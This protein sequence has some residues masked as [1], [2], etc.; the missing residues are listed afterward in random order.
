MAK[1]LYCGDCAVQTGFGRVAE[2]ILPMLAKEH[3]VVVL[4]VNYWGD[5]HDFSFRLYPAMIGGSDPFGS[6]RIAEVLQKE[7]P[8][9]V[10]AVNDIWI[11]NKLWE[12]A[13]PLKEELGFKWY[14]YFPVDSYGFFPDVFKPC[15][16]WDGMGT[17]TQFGMQEVRKAGC[18]LPCDV[19]PHGIN[20][21]HFYKLDKAACREEFK[22]SDEL[23]IVFNG[24]RNQPRKRIDLTIRGFLKF[25]EGKPDA[26][27]WLHM[28]KKDQGWDI[29]PL[30]KRMARE[31]G[32]DPTE[33]LILTSSQFDVT[34]CLPIA[35]LNRAYN[36]ADVGVNTCI[37][38]GWGLVNFEHAATGVAQVVPDH[39]SMKEVFSGIPRIPV[40][41]WEVDRNYGLDR[42]QPSPDGLADILSHYYE[43]RDDLEKVADWC[44]DMT[45]QDVFLWDTIGEAFLTVINR[46]LVAA[47]KAPRK[48]KIQEA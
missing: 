46:T 33:K 48:R 40:E 20:R 23:F 11:V 8:D 31:Y 5:P 22:L 28:G 25:A 7:K 18:D 3:E 47:P 6:H 15:H 10:L 14:G 37:G 45:Q 32:M 26:R 19:I 43:H 39:T 42:G 41:S 2:N 35:A 27:L 16:E 4:A 38:E 1:I 30:F 9:M 24:N 36:C 13:K 29:I 21:E 34:K 12:R 17:Y 44:F